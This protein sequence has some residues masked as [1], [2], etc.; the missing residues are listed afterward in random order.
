MIFFVIPYFS[1]GG[2]EKVHLQIIKSI[3]Q[4][5]RVYVLF[6]FTDGSLISTDFR[7]N[8]KVFNITHSFKK[9]LCTLL[10]IIISRITRITLFGCNSSYFY[11]LLPQISKR[12]KRIDLT[13]A[14][15]YPEKGIENFAIHYVKYIDKRIVINKK[16]LKDYEALYR[17]SGINSSYLDKFVIIP[18]GI[19]INSFNEIEIEKRHNNFQVGFVG[20]YSNEKRPELFIKIVSQDFVS[21]VS[22]KMIIDTFKLKKTDYSNIEIIEGINEPSQIRKEFSTIS[23]LIIASIREGFPLV[24]MEAMELG[25]PIITTAVG[26]IEEHVRNGIN[27]FITEKI[28]DDDFLKFC[29]EKINLLQG[30]KE[31]Y[32]KMSMAA[33]EYAVSNFNIVN[34]Q[35]AYRKLLLNG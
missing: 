28:S 8:A 25:I 20:R 16:T 7:R 19:E 13:H 30:N 34:F 31:I 32:Y 23:L 15:S 24:I 5:K 29:V 9:R 17:Y 33:R 21:I 10:L 11:V 3:N 14:F 1:I 35:N 4:Y 27:G 6:D 18:N 22:A 2:A 26:S 12:S